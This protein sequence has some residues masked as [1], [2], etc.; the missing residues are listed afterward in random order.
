M[1]EYTYEDLADMGWDDIPEPKLL[2]VGSWRL[3]ARNATYKEGKGDSNPYFMF[4]YVP[5]APLD[6]VDADKLIELGADYDVSNN[7]IFHRMWVETASDFD[8]V[9]KHLAK[10]GIELEGKSVKETLAAFKGTEVIG[11]IGIKVFTDRSNE[12]RQENVV[13]AFAPIE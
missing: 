12:E 8:A 7:R 10:H 13:E 3:K 9:R 6:D 1:A 11:A 2:P 4:V 5:S